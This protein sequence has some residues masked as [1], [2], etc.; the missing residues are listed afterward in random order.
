MAGK[1]ILWLFLFCV[2]LLIAVYI[3][4][5]ESEHARRDRAEGDLDEMGVGVDAEVQARYDLSNQ[6]AKLYIYGLVIED[7]MK[8]LY[9]NHKVKLV[10]RGCMIGG[11]EYKR[12]MRY[13]RLVKTAFGLPLDEQK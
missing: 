11:V 9:K 10:Y 1:R 8:T 7:Q 3:G 6:Q 13:N 5:G 12:E 4:K 2:A